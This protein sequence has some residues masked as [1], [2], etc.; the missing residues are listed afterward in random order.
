MTTDMV[1]REHA[2][3]SAPS[4][5]PPGALTR[6]GSGVA[7]H[8][9]PLFLIALI[10]LPY[11]VVAI[12]L[13]TFNAAEFLV[14]G[15]FAMA[16]GLLWGYG[17]DLSFGHGMFF[18][19][20]AYAAGLISHQIANVLLGLV[21]AAVVTMLLAAVLA[22]VIVPRAQGIY[23]AMVTLA[24]GQI[25]YF[26]AF[27]LNSVTGGETGLNGIDRGR[28]FGLDLADNATFYFVTAGVMFLAT[29]AAIRIVRSPFG[30]ILKGVQ[31]N[32]SRVA[33]LGFR[34]VRYRQGA[35]V[36]SAGLAGIAGGLSAF[37]YLTVPPDQIAW[38]TT[39][40]A[41]VM[42]MIGGLGT[43]F[44]PLLGAILF[45]FLEGRLNSITN[46]WPALIGIM[47]VAI[48]LVAPRGIVGLLE[49]G[50]RL[51]SRRPAREDPGEQAVVPARSK[52]VTR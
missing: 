24:V 39:G 42:V 33:F 34:A 50:W 5:R 41:V 25:F 22:L 6:L 51:V 35:F 26:L 44:G 49:A 3:K 43:I 9:M 46:Y 2:R 47:F 38:T 31:Q 52:G 40:Q 36:L 10:A 15:L 20:G 23:F 14:W 29:A 11:V 28:L 4:G 8:P 12:G 27:R 13:S 32:R 19:I 17:G 45:E 18:G 7:R 16:V 21:V 37:L 48:V 1:A 30:R